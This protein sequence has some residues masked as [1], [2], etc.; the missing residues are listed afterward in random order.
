MEWRE[1]DAKWQRVWRENETFKA[2]QGSKPKFF[3]TVAYPYVSGPMHVGHAR[4]YTVPDIIARYKRMCGF[5]VLFPMAFHFTGTPLVGAATR[6]QNRDPEFL[7]MLTGVFGVKKDEISNFEDPQYFGNYFARESDLSYK[8]GM[9]LL[10]YSIDWN[11]EFTTI[12]DTYNKF[13]EWQYRKLMDMDLVSKGAHPVKWCPGCQNPVTDHD[14]LEGE[15]VK[16]VEYSL[17]KFRLG[18]YVLPAATLRP[19][20]IFGVTNLW[21]NPEVDYVAAQVDDE[22]WIVSKEAVK[23]LR[24]QGFEVGEVNEID[25]PIIGRNVDAPIIHRKIPVLPAE[26]V[27]PANASGVVYSVPSHAPYDY[28]ALRELQQN[29]DDLHAYGIDSE[30]VLAIE[31]ISLIDLSGYGESPAI[32]VVKREGISDQKDARLEEAT[33]E[34]YRKEF[35]RGMVLDW[36]PNYGGMSVSAAKDEVHRDL[37]DSGEGS[38]MYEFSEKPVTCRCGTRC[39]VKVVEDQW[40]LNYSNSDWKEKARACLANMQL[41]PPE[42]R[43][44]FE[45]TIGWLEDWPCTRRVGMGTPAPWDPSW[46]IESLSDSTIYMIYYTISH[47][48]RNIDPEKL[49]DEIFDFVFLGLGDVADLSESSCIDEDKLK[50]MRS[51]V[52]YWYPLDY[53]LSANELISNHLTFHIFHHVALFPFKMWPKGIVSFGMA[54]LKGSKMSSSKGNIIPINEATKEYGADVVRLYLASGVDPWQDFDWR[55]EEAKAMVRHLERFYNQALEIIDLPNTGRPELDLPDRWMLSRLQGH[56][57]S[58]SDALESFETREASQ[59]AFF[60]MMRDLR[61]YLER[62]KDSESRNWTLKRVLDRW[63]R[64]L[65]P[66]APH[67]SEEIWHQMGQEGLVVTAEWPEVEDNLVDEVAEFVEEYLEGLRKDLRKIFQVMDIERPE[68][69]CFYV[70][71]DWKWKAYHLALRHVRKGKVEMGELIQEGRKELPDIAPD[72]LANF[73]KGAVK[74][75]RNVSEDRMD[76]ISDEEIDELSIL[77]EESEFIQKRLDVGEVDVFEADDPDRYD[78]QGRAGHSIPFK[79]AIYVK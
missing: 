39:M 66:F 16:I 22:K 53:R 46:I 12:D 43:G 42:T 19:E 57:K 50:Q 2:S 14:L 62:S 51:E 58:V 23:K 5:N 30:A 37:L 28:V 71:E 49:T 31:P 8:K 54:L 61:R 55:P 3:L 59:H 20:T 47:I 13:I 36:V 76:L 69:V 29:P 33:N 1:I 64:M 72:K 70:A 56:I 38:L 67:V 65:A 75:L 27:D 21:L 63:I 44:Q 24:N 40:F 45:Y 48:L 79:P 18:D 17:L 60:L 41:I 73:F 25:E 34:V 11:R 77:R 52:E 7:E 68:R 9:Q 4:T 10:G 6:V 35:S 74:E 32:D 15:G 78:P 26:F